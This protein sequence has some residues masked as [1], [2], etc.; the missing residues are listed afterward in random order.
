[1]LVK[2][3]EHI[4]VQ[5]LGK[6]SVLLNT[7]TERYYSLNETGSLMVELFQ[8]GKSQAEV[9]K[10]ICIQYKAQEEKVAGDC[11]ALLARLQEADLI[12]A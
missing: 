6:D 7:E 8:E 1:M 3:K 11:Q 12:D 10:E 9:I 5:K 4:L 2:F